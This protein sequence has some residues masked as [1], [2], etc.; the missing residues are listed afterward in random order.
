[1]GIGPFTT[2]APPGVYTRTV[3]EPVLGQLLGGL[4]IPVLIGTGRETLSQ[5]DFELIRG[6]SSVADTP[7]FAEDAAGRF[8]QGGPPNNP[9]LG[10]ADGVRSQFRVR[11]YP[12]VDGDG[13][14]RVTFDVSKVSVKVN[15][16][17]VVVAGVDGPNGLVSLLV[18]PQP[19]DVVLVDYFFHRRDT[20]ITDD[21]SSQITAAT[22]LLVAPKAEPYNVVFGSSDTLLVTSN[23]SSV[24]STILLT[25]G[26]RLSADVANDI[27]AAAVPGLTA[28]IHIDAQ[29]LNHVQL[30]AQ[31]NI[32]I[33]SGNANGALG[34][35]PGDYT[36]RNKSFV[37]FNGPIV[38]GSDGGITTTDPSKVSV[39]IN[40]TP[41]LA[42]AVD[43]Q[44]QV[45]TLAVAPIQGAIVAITYYFNTFQDTFDYLPNSNIISVGNVGIAPGRRDYLNGPDFV[46]VNEGDQSKIQWGTAWQVVAGEKT[47]TNP[48]DSVQVT[49]LLIDDRIYGSPCERFVDAATSQVSETK[50]VM[51]LSPTTGNGRDTPLGQSLYQTITNGR[52]D[53]PT[54]RPDLVSV[55]VGKNFRDAQVRPPAV[56]LAVDSATNT[57]VLR[58]PVPADYQVFATF[59]YNRIGDDVFTMNVVAGGPSG[60]GQYTVFSQKTNQFLLGTKFGVKTGL[61]QIIQWPS[62]TETLPDAF[63]SGDGV[64]VSETVTV[65]FDS[66]L[67][68]AQNAS[69]SNLEQSP[70]DIYSYTRI[71][72]G[73]VIDGNAAVS[74]DLSLPYVSC[75]LGQPV[76]EPLVFSA[77][78]NMLLQIDGVV[79]GAVALT[80][81][82]TIAQVATAINAVVDADVQVHT[83]GSG[84]FASTSPNNLASAVTYGSKVILKVKGRNLPSLTNGLTASVLV[85]VPTGV[86]QTNG[87]SKAGLSPNL[88]SS[89]SY[90]SI[91]QAAILVGTK[92]SPFNIQ[93]GVT[94]SIQLTVDGADFSAVLPSGSAVTI[95]DIVTAVNNSY[96]TVASA[97]DVA[98]FTAALVSLVNDIRTEYMT[99]IAS[100]VYHLVADGINTILSPA[101]T[102][103]PTSVT[104]V[105]ELKT[106][107]NLHLSQAGIH[108]LDDS[109]NAESLPVAIN[110]QTAISLAYD[111]KK[112]YNDHL[113]Q[114]GVHGSNDITNTVSLSTISVS[115]TGAILD[116]ISTTEV[117]ITAPLHGLANGDNVFISGVL[118]T[119]EANS[120]AATDWMVA[121]VTANTFTLTGSVFANAYISGGTVQ[122]VTAEEALI[123]DL[124]A[125]VN[126]HY[127]QSG[128]HLTNDVVN[129]IIVVNAS[130]ATAGPWTTASILVNQLK[131]FLNLHIASATYHNV[132]DT[133]NTIAIADSTAVSLTSVITLA[134][135]VKAAYNAH[136]V[137]AQGAY[138]VHGFNDLVNVVTAAL[139]EVVAFVGQGSRANKLV[140]ISRTNT[141][142]SSVVFKS[143]STSGVPLGFISGISASRTQPTATSISAALNGDAPFSALAAA[144]PIPVSGLGTFLG[145][146]SR[147]AGATSTVAFTNVVNTTFIADTGIGIIPGTSGAIGDAAQSGFSVVSSSGL[148]G[149]HGTG[150]PGQ[151]YSDATTGLRFTILPA[152]AGDYTSGG[153]F[154]L[155][156]NQ[157]Y[158]AD[159]SIP[160]KEIPGIEISVFNTIGMNPG[161]TALLSTFKRTGSQPKVGD[162][163][164]AS[165]EFAKTNLNT[166]LFRDLKSIQQNFGTPT[167]DNPLSLG[168]RLAL[169]NGAV[170]I[171]LKQVLRA[172]GSSQA[173]VGS[174]K[175]A[176]D[177]QQK[178]MTG[179]VKPDV[180]TVLATDPEVFGYLNQ[181]CIFMSSP[182]QEG[183]RIAVA[184]PAVGTTALGVQSIARGLN[185]ELMILTYPDSYIVTV[186]DNQGNSSQQ[187]VDAS[188]MAAAIAGSTC[189]PSIDVATPLTRRQ[190]FGFSQLGRILD[191]TEANQIAVSGVSIIEQADVGQRVRHGLT[192]NTATVITRTPS[193]TLTIHHVQQTMR[194]VLDPFIGQKFTGAL[195][196]SAETA[197]TGAFATMIDQQIVTK[198]AGVSVSVDPNDPTIMRTEAIYVPVFP[199]EYI[200]TTLQIRVR[201]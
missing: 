73:V 104:L 87:S 109:L 197:M 110:L 31:G 26:S 182:R 117:E 17:S 151:T 81:L 44:N 143:L 18:P 173:S 4:R 145:I 190:I 142:I 47:G 55:L 25:P 164:Y 96:M 162:V 111:L 10:N 115:I 161:T 130:D 14:G 118:G 13:I 108:Q 200:V 68:P 74:V 114:L 24:I 132:A 61:S 171:G 169:L 127:L 83:D 62:G 153:S 144:Y 199:L 154:T 7:I 9:V 133:T 95:E 174:Y 139:P 57:F 66:S 124:K 90:D 35:N 141:V 39:T 128:S 196:K 89:G 30:I 19:T 50:F 167:P 93:A 2:Y 101:A 157:T 1:M 106:K 119:T 67:Q 201:L 75:I 86:G 60:I 102:D 175:A 82:T 27:N 40:G 41:V 185:S 122:S 38:D 78:D 186:T 195:L 43:G 194:R 140:L 160:I 6:S 64:P 116:P 23:D 65:T 135:A 53:L 63:H 123:N 48:F 54:N 134:D 172:T 178:P 12:I 121:N 11:N 148:L 72:G 59:W 92:V 94:D 8:V 85:L 180:I 58:D 79:L 193:V 120:V 179:N 191:P 70:Y 126:L 88:T 49:G 28:A 51:S 29:G 33:G 165:Y 166:A 129:T 37:V 158:T 20:R 52:I 188:Y 91:N 113:D 22:A 36:N 84:T 16:Q 21:V 189:N 97:A 184:G 170:L 168:A 163:Y 45:V 56:V 187:L 34:L 159:A 147:T 71:F 137:Q 100:A 176:I 103:L 155:I 5:S 146:S 192:T 177:E 112:K 149:T 99:H 46:V 152:S 107:Y 125:K 3:T 198:V 183:E 136:R 156:V 138:N 77:T 131:A 42:T 15:G 181:H 80:G 105:N 76:T 98:T 69:F 32:L 150:T